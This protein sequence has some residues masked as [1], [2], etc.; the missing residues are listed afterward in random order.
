MVPTELE[1]VNVALP[2]QPDA[3]K[4]LIVQTAGFARARKRRLDAAPLRSDR[5][6]SGY[7][8]W[9]ELAGIP[10]VEHGFLPRDEYLGLAAGMD[11]ALCA[12][13]AESFGCA[14][15]E[16]GGR[17]CRLWSHPWSRP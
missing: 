15:A 3:R 2:S 8:R 7:A 4:N 13:L 6:P 14:A 5:A 11:A 9:L 12:S 16:F 17:L 10:H 1:G